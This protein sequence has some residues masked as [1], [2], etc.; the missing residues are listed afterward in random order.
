MTAAQALHELRNGS[1]GRATFDVVTEVAAKVARSGKYRTPSGSR[2]WSEHDVEDLVGDF[3]GSVDRAVA[4]AVECVDADH[5]RSK[6]HR[7]LVR[8]I[9]D[10]WRA[11]PRGVL[12]RRTERRLNR[13]PEVRNV[14]PRHWALAAFTSVA[15]WSGDRGPLDEAAEK[16]TVTP[17][18][19]K[20]EEKEKATPACTTDSLDDVCDAVLNEAAAPVE[21][22]LVL[23][24]VSDRII[25]RDLNH[26]ASRS[27]V[28]GA[29][30]EAVDDD[31]V[32]SVRWR[33]EVESA[34]VAAEVIFGQLDDNER[35]LL[36]HLDQS[37]RAIAANPG[38]PLG[39]SAA[40]TKAS[41]LRVK[42][43]AA[44]EAAP[45]RRLLVRCLLEVRAEWM[46]ATGQSED[47]E[48]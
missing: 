5:L 18:R 8:L 14:S 24:V 9:F 6:I 45:D 4:L 33:G 44:L 31:F 47:D 41:A 38:I 7:A 17:V 36:P 26:V 25:P 39:K 37:A 21:R 12:W 19:P 35:L 1:V 13:R 46:E 23:T 48:P 27:H 29:A 42:L 15:H 32:L 11:T 3:F 30:E 40:A 20:T 43:Q 2:R 28:E 34:R 22:P 16:V 10:R